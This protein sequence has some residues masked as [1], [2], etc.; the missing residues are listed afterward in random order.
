MLRVLLDNTFPAFLGQ[1][2][3][4]LSIQQRVYSPRGGA[5][6]VTSSLVTVHLYRG[7]GVPQQL[8]L[9]ASFLSMSSRIR[10]ARSRVSDN[11]QEVQHSAHLSANKPTISDSTRI[12]H[13]GSFSMRLRVQIVPWPFPH[14][15]GWFFMLHPTSMGGFSFDSFPINAS[16][17]STRGGGRG[18]PSHVLCATLHENRMRK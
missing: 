9:L 2:T 1:P 15:N 10:Y 8:T 12:L 3:L 7:Y 11:V 13:K 14:P 5:I 4:S 17:E 18:R 6:F 16:R